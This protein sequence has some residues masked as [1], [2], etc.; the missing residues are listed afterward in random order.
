MK[1]Y[2]IR[3]I[4]FLFVGTLLFLPSQTFRVRAD[5]AWETISSYTTYYN[6]EEQGRAHNIERATACIDG[7]TLQPYGEFSFNKTVGKRTKET[8]YQQAKIIV[9]GEYVQ[10]VGGG[11]CQVS[12][13]LYNVS[14]K[15][16]LVV[17]EY[18][19]RKP[20]FLC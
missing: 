10:G 9:G 17:E 19:C 15:S 13:T 12:T 2:T 11:V 16:G 7:I 8:G 1:I 18:V 3:T 4:A 14:L 6:P 5:N 20:F